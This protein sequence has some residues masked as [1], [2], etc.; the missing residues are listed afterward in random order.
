[1]KKTVHNIFDLFPQY[2]PTIGVMGSASGKI[3]RN[4][5]AVET[6]R[7]VGREIA[8]HNCVLSNGACPG[9][10]D[11]AAKGAKELGG[12]TMG[13]SPAISIVSHIQKYK[14]P[15]D[16]YDHFLFTG[17]G[18]LMRDIIN[19]RSCDGVIILPGGTGTLNEFTAAFDEGKPIGVL[20]GQGGIADH[21]REILKHSERDISKNMVFSS[22]PKK[23]VAK[24]LQCIKRQAAPLEID[25]YLI[26]EN[27]INTEKD[28]LAQRDFFSSLQAKPI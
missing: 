21:I 17:M 6:C 25:E 12:Y 15:I 4:S 16:H 27:G 5:Q 19:V 22:N 14:S 10:P 8:R 11:E 2:Q 3:M 28:R 24:V 13:I 7:E 1:M 23:L 26:G 9:L 18:L 20:E